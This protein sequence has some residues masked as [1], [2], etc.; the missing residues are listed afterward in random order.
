[1]A[2]NR[3]G[4]SD[5]DKIEEHLDREEKLLRIQGEALQKLDKAVDGLWSQLKIQG[6]MR[7]V[8]LIY[9]HGLRAIHLVI[10]EV[11]K[12]L[13]RRF[14]AVTE[15]PGRWHCRS[16]RNRQGGRGK[17]FP[18]FKDCIGALDGSHV[19]IK[20]KGPCR[21]CISQSQ[22]WSIAERVGSLR[23]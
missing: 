2:R 18:G 1:M 23:L 16:P 19:P 3:L 8:R 6:E 22:R 17:F 12:G 5:L 14:Y 7:A 11:L 15:L 4:P 13:C 10:K 9:Q 20:L 21:R